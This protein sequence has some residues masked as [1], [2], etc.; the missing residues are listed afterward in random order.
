MDM[1]RLFSAQV[2]GELCP[3]ARSCNKRQRA[4]A[5]PRDKAKGQQGMM[6][7]EST[8]AGVRGAADATG[9]DD[10]AGAHGVSG[11]SG[12]APTTGAGAGMRIMRC[13]SE[14]A[15][16]GPTVYFQNIEL[17]AGYSQ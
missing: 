16:S 3:A 8:H 14:G 15:V 6:P 5:S 13:Q 10:A 4:S 1:A 7:T 17:P 11:V 2:C 12:T 9:A